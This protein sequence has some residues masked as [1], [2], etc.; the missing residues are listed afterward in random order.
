MVLCT[1]ATRLHGRVKCADVT[2]SLTLCRHRRRV[3]GWVNC[4]TWSSS[5]SA[6]CVSASGAGCSTNKHIAFCQSLSCSDS[7]YQY[8]HSVQGRSQPRVSTLTT[9]GCARCCPCLKPTA[10]LWSSQR[11]LVH[12]NGQLPA[13]RRLS[14]EGTRQQLI[15]WAHNCRTA[16]VLPSLAC[17]TDS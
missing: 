3:V 10:L 17:T 9:S 12:S 11:W 13:A 2:K 5:P 16:V 4:A 15:W 14:A 6:T 7:P 1:A 8:K